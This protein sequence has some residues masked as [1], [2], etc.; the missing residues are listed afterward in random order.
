VLGW[1]SKVA[2][3]RGVE[4]RV[5]KP[6]RV[7]AIVSGGPDSFGYMVQWLAR[8]CTVHALSF[9]YGQ[10]GS[11]EL[12]VAKRLIEK[13]NRLAEEK[14]W[15]RIVEHRVVDMGF[16]RSLWISSQLTSDELE[17]TE[18]YQPTVVVPIRN[19]VMLSIAAAYAYSLLD[20]HP[21]EHVYVVYG[22]HYN[23]IKPREDTWEPLYPDCSPECIESLQTAFRICH[24]RGA[25]RLEIW[26]PS[27]QGLT[28]AENLRRTY[29]L[30]GDLVYETWSCYLSHRYHCGR[31]ES[32][33]NRHQAFLEAGIPDCTLYE[34]PPGK[35]EDFV[36]VGD[37]YVHKSCAH[38]YA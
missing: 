1:L 38:R 6:C 33:R 12:E 2:Q 4:P 3:L 34:H 37:A 23:D 17:V 24:F 21:D 35:Q 20:K 9:N 31:C 18:E 11:K 32:C 29:E 13:A 30:V 22:S 7:V 8:G 19:V 36:K 15:G 14:G 26:S 5:E 28:K 16:M 25:R 27:R 10:K